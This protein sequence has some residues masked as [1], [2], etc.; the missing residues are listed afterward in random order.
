MKKNQNIDLRLYARQSKQKELMQLLAEPSNVVQPESESLFFEPLF[1]PALLEYLQHHALSENVQ[2]H[3]FVADKAELLEIFVQKWALAANW[4]KALFAVQ[5]RPYLKLYIQRGCL[6]DAENELLFFS[7]CGMTY[8]RRFYMKHYEFHCRE[9][10]A[11][12]LAPEYENDL[13][14]YIGC[15]RKMFAD[16]AEILEAEYPELYRQYLLYA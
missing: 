13:R 5:Y 9:A 6:A 2:E 3:L 4:E 16:L 15:Q 14:F 1:R 11:M 8:L 7:Q 12:L 10:E